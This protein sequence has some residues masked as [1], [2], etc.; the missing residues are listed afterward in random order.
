MNI[1]LLV[2]ALFV[3]GSVHLQAADRTYRVQN[4]S[5]GVVIVTAATVLGSN[6]TT[7]QPSTSVKEKKPRGQ[8]STLKSKLKQP[9][10]YGKKDF[11]LYQPRFERHESSQTKDKQSKNHSSLSAEEQAR[12]LFGAKHRKK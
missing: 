9:C 12:V 2:S 4:L 6:P 7:N 8:Q 11:N 1:R 3:L 5:K 10:S